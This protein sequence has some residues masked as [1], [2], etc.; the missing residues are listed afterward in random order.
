MLTRLNRVIKS[1]SR[2]LFKEKGGFGLFS[3]VI[4]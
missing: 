3:A 2:L 1:Y 4:T